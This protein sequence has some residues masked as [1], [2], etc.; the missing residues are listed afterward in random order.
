MAHHSANPGASCGGFWNS[1]G[2]AE[3]LIDFSINIFTP[4]TPLV[5]SPTPEVRTRKMAGVWINERVLISLDLFFGG[6]GRDGGC[7]VNCKVMQWE[8]NPR[9]GKHFVIRC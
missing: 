3:N 1:G 4:P 9:P 7:C 8:A 5:L 6:G 2:S